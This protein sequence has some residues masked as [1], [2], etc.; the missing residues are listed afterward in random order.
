MY[1]IYFMWFGSFD[2]I[3]TRYKV[4]GGVACSIK[5]LEFMICRVILVLY[6]FDP[7]INSCI[8]Y[9]KIFNIV[10]LKE[11]DLVLTVYIFQQSYLV[12]LL[13]YRIQP[14]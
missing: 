5:C 7:L 1:Q 2:A 4:I 11:S 9:A 3:D 6:H 8:Y 13:K 12:T 14:A 10:Y